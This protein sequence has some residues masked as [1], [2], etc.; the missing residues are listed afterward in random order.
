[1]PA[2]QAHLPGGRSR[3]AA[4]HTT[5]EVIQQDFVAMWAAGTW[6]GAEPGF[7]STMYPELRV[8]QVKW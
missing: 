4:W 5:V 8:V 1:M 7:L 6:V 3:R 2:E